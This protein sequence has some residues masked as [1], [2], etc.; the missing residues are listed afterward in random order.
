MAKTSYL[1]IPPELEDKYFSGLQVMDRFIIPR[2]LVKT[3]NLSNAAR[4][5]LINRSYLPTIAN[6]WNAFTD[7]QKQAWKDI[8]P[9]PHPNGYRAFV[10]DQT[11]R[12]KL[13]L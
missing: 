9:Y 8:D 12:I 4:T 5:K 13:G 3:T 7:E 2:I 10:A 1:T 6:L 11:Q